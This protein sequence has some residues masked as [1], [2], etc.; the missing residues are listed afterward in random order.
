MMTQ[1]TAPLLP[2]AR[3]RARSGR[4]QVMKWPSWPRRL[5]HWMSNSP[6][7]SLPHACPSVTPLLGQSGVQIVQLS[8]SRALSACTFAAWVGDFWAKVAQIVGE[9]NQ[10]YLKRSDSLV[11]SNPQSLSSYRTGRDLNQQGAREESRLSKGQTE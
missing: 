5:N 11:G 10:E 7:V 8:G 9:H 1:P 6:W 4:Q 2:C 3:V